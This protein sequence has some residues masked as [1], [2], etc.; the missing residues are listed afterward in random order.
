M[1]QRMNELAVKAANG[2]N[3]LDA[4]ET[5]KAAIQ[6]VS[7]QRSALGAIQNR[8][9]HTI[10]NN[11]LLKKEHRLR[12]TIRQLTAQSQYRNGADPR[13]P[14]TAYRSLT[15]DNELHRAKDRINRQQSDPLQ[16][17]QPSLYES[18][19]GQQ[20]HYQEHDR[21]IQH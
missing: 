5:I 18:G 13:V 16:T 14:N 15:S 20:A 8:L 9:E 12:V 2:T 3:S 10:N 19:Q 1:L 6:R 21:K 7:T 11:I 4:I 17:V